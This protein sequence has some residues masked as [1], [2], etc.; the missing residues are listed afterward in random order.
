M[1][2]FLLTG[3]SN[4]AGRGL[5]DAVEPIRHP[6][7]LMLREGRWT[8]ATEPLHEDRPGRAGI[9]IAMSFAQQLLERSPGVKIGLVPCAE[10][11][12]PL[13]RWMPGA[14][15]SER[16]LALGRR[17]VADGPLRGILWHQ[18][19]SDSVNKS[20]ATSYGPR[21]A[22]VVGHLREQ[23]GATDV[24]V[25][26]G[27]LGYFLRQSDDHV[28]FA[29][30]NDALRGA[31]DSVPLYA[32]ASATD[33]ADMGDHVHFDSTSLREFGQRYATE[34]L[35]LIQHHHLPPLQTTVG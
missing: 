14:D 4:M 29:V 16:A 9:G 12:S 5:V 10:G 28:Y 27:E 1:N 19:E 34:F 3:Q 15:L 21:L 11:G 7:I 22:K 25:I 2:I 30:V 24:P 17:A 20:D 31:A 23:L 18:G 33:L 8:E 6:D 26:A 32:C 35:E 13:S